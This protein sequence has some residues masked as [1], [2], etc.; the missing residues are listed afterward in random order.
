[1]SALPTVPDEAKNLRLI[2]SFGYWAIN[3]QGSDREAADRAQFGAPIVGTRF[4]TATPADEV[5]ETL[6]NQVTF[7][8]YT[9]EDGSQEQSRQLPVLAK[10]TELARDTRYVVLGDIELWFGCSNLIAFRSPIT[11]LIMRQPD[12]AGFPAQRLNAISSTSPRVPWQEFYDELAKLIA[13][14]P[15]YE[16]ES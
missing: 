15:S 4:P 2:H 16:S 3:S 8:G 6:S 11:G 13:V 1:M 9:I 7:A 12:S 14:L 10:M 5:I